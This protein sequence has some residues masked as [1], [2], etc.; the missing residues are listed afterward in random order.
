MGHEGFRR[1]EDAREVDAGNPTDYF[2][3][4]TPL[5]IFPFLSIT[6]IFDGHV[7]AC[8][9]ADTTQKRALYKAPFLLDP[10]LGKAV[11]NPKV[12]R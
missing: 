4:R 12:H 1:S 10:F 8:S 2:G 9:K 7:G 3:A 11:L 6:L 5:A